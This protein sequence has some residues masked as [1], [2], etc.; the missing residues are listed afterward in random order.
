MESIFC[1]SC[2][3]HPIPI[4]NASRAAPSSQPEPNL[5]EFEIN[6]LAGKP[7]TAQ[8][9]S[10]SFDICHSNFVIQARPAAIHGMGGVGKTRAAIE[11]AWKHANDYRALLFISAD[12]PEA[13]HRNLAAFCGPLLRSCISHRPLRAMSYGHRVERRISKNRPSAGEKLRL[14]LPSSAYRTSNHCNAN[15]STTPF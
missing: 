5:T 7:T 13:L 15:S 10:I 11:Y 14:A 1:H 3:C 9:S 6:V 2:F 8:R 12:T 4:W